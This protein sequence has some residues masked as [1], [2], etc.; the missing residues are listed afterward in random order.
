MEPKAKGKR[1][2]Q[3]EKAAALL[4]QFEVQFDETLNDRMGHLH[5]RMVAFVSES[6]LPITHVITVLQMLLS[7]ATEQAMKKFK[8]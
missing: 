3:K 7:E 5:N 8:G 6:R 1:A 4:K 2:T